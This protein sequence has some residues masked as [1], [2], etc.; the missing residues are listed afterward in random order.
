M[1]NPRARTPSRPLSFSTVTPLVA[2]F[3]IGPEL[4]ALSERRAASNSTRAWVLGQLPPRAFLDSGS[5][6]V[7]RV[8]YNPLPSVYGGEDDQVNL[9]CKPECHCTRV[10]AGVCAVAHVPGRPWCDIRSVVATAVGPSK[11]K[12]SLEENMPWHL[13]LPVPP[14]ANSQ[15]QAQLRSQLSHLAGEREAALARIGQMEDVLRLNF[16]SPL[17]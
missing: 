13:Q 17:S 3:W 8:G 11:E 10:A 4:P 6:D 15:R 12:K 2:D 5:W 7:L 9:R 14:R 16:F 1:S